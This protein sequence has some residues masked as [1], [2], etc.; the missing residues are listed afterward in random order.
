MSLHVPQACPGLI[1]KPHPLPD[2]P[3]HD[4]DQIAFYGH[5]QVVAG[6]G[7][8]ER[9]EIAFNARLIGLDD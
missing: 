9:L 1:D 4:V 8:P 6:H 2:K 3:A 5:T 7:Y